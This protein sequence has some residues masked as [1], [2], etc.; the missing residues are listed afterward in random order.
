MFMK[1]HES[2]KS[3][4]VALCDKE[5]LGR[6]LTEGETVLDLKGYAY[7]YKGREA[8]A[9]EAREAMKGAT[10]INLVGKRSVALAEKLGLV[11][12]KEIR[13]IGGTPHAQVYRV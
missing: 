7:F 2:E 10:S 3:V 4:V 8:T 1:I 11:S 13:R 12:K 9:E 5:L 6:V